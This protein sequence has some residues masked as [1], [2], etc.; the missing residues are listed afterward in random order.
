[1]QGQFIPSAFTFD[2][3]LTAASLL[4]STEKEPPSS[5]GMLAAW[6]P[7]LKQTTFF[8]SSLAKQA[9]RSLIGVVAH[10]CIK[11]DHTGT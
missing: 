6:T 11:K 5:Y 7:G 1:M 8:K 3:L 2:C 9:L 10:L 4:L